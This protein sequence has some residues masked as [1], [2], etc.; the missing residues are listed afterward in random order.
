[1]L[2]HSRVDTCNSCKEDLED[3]RQEV[4]I[5]G[6]LSGHPNIM[7]LKCAFEDRHNV[8]LI[9]ELCSGGKLFDR[10]LARGF[11]RWAN[12]L[13]HPSVSAQHNGSSNPSWHNQRCDCFISCTCVCVC[14]VRRMQLTSAA[15]S[16]SLSAT[17]T[18]GTSSTGLCALLCCTKAMR[19]RSEETD[20]LVHSSTGMS[21]TICSWQEPDAGKLPAGL[22][23]TRR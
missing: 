15:A 22:G 20:Q 18:H 13:L 4:Q 2:V 1:M 11:Y 16:C 8:H 12:L 6:H 17:A 21:H 10:I 19:S 23:S 7:Q 9:M 14:A 3:V 5:L